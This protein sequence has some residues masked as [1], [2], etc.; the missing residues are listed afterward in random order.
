MFTTTPGR[1]VRNSCLLWFLVCNDFKEGG[2]QAMDPK[3]LYQPYMKGLEA[4]LE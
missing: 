3:A 2:V 4:V 1:L